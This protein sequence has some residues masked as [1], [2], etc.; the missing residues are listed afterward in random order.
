MSTQASLV[1]ERACLLQDQAELAKFGLGLL[2]AVAV[3]IYDDEVLFDLLQLGLHT[4]R[5]R[6]D[7]KSGGES[8]KT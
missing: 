3:L 8:V 7:L 5:I 6:T 2:Q 1:K 4:A